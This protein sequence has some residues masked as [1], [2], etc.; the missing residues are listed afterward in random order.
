MKC[1]TRAGDFEGSINVY[2]YGLAKTNSGGKYGV[3]Q[4]YGFY[5]NGSEFVIDLGGGIYPYVNLIPEPATVLFLLSGAFMVRKRRQYGS[6]GKGRKGMAARKWTPALLLVS[7]LCASTAL[8]KSVFIISKHPIPSQAQAYII[9]G[10]QADYQ[11]QV[12]IDTYNPGF[13]V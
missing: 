2:G 5:P 3:G 8:A 12:D 1:G 13:G 6:F 4:V 9:E 10:D 11:T 7:V